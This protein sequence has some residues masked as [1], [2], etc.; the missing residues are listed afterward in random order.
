MCST[1][2]NSFDEVDRREIRAHLHAK[3]LFKQY[4]PELLVI[5]WDYEDERELSWYGYRGRIKFIPL[6]KW[7]LFTEQIS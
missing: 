1:Y 7:L 3:E 5:T 6:W 4:K 2:A